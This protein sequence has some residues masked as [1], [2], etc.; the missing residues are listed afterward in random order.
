M[1]GQWK[2]STGHRVAEGRQAA[3]GAGGWRG[4]AEEV[5]SESEEPD[6]REQRQI[7]LQGLQSGRGNQRHV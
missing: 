5:D 1:H 6:A 7:H 3:D 4:P 2:S